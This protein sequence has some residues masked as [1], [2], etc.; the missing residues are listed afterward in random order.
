[1]A[2]SPHVSPAPAVFKAVSTP[3]A[4][5][6]AGKAV[7]LLPA[8]LPPFPQPSDVGNSSL[9][10]TDS[11]IDFCYLERAPEAQILKG[12]EVPNSHQNEG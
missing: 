12:T 6:Q 3:V 11:A 10:P 5:E 8:V 1:M 9:S 7:L 2:L 4:W